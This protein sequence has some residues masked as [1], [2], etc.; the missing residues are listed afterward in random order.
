MTQSLHQSFQILFG[1][2][3]R[4][5]RRRYDVLSHGLVP[6]F[7]DLFC[8]L[9]SRKVTSHAGLG[10]LSYLD[11]YRIRIAKVLRS[12]AVKIRYIFEYILVGCFHFLRDDSSLAGAHCAFGHRSAFG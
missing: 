9:I 11:L 12:H 8:H 6:Y 2:N 4:K 1:I 10:A 7:A 5:T 3:S